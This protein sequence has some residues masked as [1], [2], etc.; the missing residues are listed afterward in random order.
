MTK[1]IGYLRASTTKEKQPNS[2]AIQRSVI[3][4][5]CAR[6]NYDLE[7]VVFEFASGRKN[8]PLFNE[9]LARCVENGMLLVCLSPDRCSRDLGM[10]SQLGQAQLETLRFTNMGSEVPNI[11]VLACMISIGM[12]EALNCSIRVKAAYAFLK[13]QNPDHPWGNPNIHI[14]REKAIQS[15]KDRAKAHNGRIRSI[16]SVFKSQGHTMKE[17]A[18]LLKDLGVKSRR[19][20]EL[21]QFNLYRI[22]KA[23]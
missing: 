2:L 19:G 1:A 5:Y 13:S 23:A 22:M 14:A 10:F 16:V 21:T 11:T 17:I 7:D 6:N 3:E 20:Q 9:T 15:N 8:R 12:A 18:A 4:Q